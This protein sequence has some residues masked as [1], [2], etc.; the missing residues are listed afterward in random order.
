MT[1]RCRLAHTS[2]G[3]ALPVGTHSGHLRDGLT[4]DDN[5]FLPKHPA[6]AS[7]GTDS[8]FGEGY[9]KPRLLFVNDWS[10]KVAR[11]DVPLSKR[12]VQVRQC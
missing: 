8:T 11:F 4:A 5:D 12:F 1:Q 10:L 7:V 6:G 3:S 9:P 2:S